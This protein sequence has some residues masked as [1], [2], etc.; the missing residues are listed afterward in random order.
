MVSVGTAS[1]VRHKSI[2]E[3]GGG[4]GGDPGELIKG[5]DDWRSDEGVSGTLKPGA[6][7]FGVVCIAPGESKI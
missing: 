7:R 4:G 2:G 1:V 5:E 6:K 3:I